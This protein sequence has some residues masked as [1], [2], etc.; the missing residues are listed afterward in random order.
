MVSCLSVV[1]ICGI[2][3]TTNALYNLYRVYAD[4]CYS[5]IDKSSS[6]ELTETINSMY[7][8][9]RGSNECYVFLDDIVGSERMLRDGTMRYEVAP[10][11]FRASRWFTRGWT[12]PEL[13]APSS[14]Y[15]YD[16]DGN[17]IASR[18]EHHNMISGA[19]GIHSDYLLGKKY[20]W[21]AS[22]AQR[23]SWAATRRTTRLE[24]RAYSLLGIFDVNLPLLY[25]EGTKAFLRLQLA[26]IQQSNDQSIFAW[27]MDRYAISQFGILAQSPAN[28]RSSESVVS[29]RSATSN[30]A[31]PI[32]VTNRGISYFYTTSANDLMPNLWLF[33]GTRDP[34]LRQIQLPCAIEQQSNENTNITLHIEPAEGSL[35]GSFTRVRVIQRRRPTISISRLLSTL[36]IRENKVH[37]AYTQHLETREGTVRVEEKGNRSKVDKLGESIVRP[38][39]L[40][41]RVVGS[42]ALCLLCGLAV[43][44]DWNWNAMLIFGGLIWARELAKGSPVFIWHEDVLVVCLGAALQTKYSRSSRPT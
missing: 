14:V 12:L 35:R 9:Y 23:M 34:G 10:Q 27:G 21:E 26:I 11:S 3:T 41:L 13:L 20:I 19:T 4:V 39:L 5:C 15:F 32:Q 17:L 36:L 18:S 30:F 22:I 42:F 24:D 40:T 8:W 38:A 1:N 31:E 2:M 6:A 44:I 43:M 29:A 33:S 28:F 7:L 37:I 16:Q 25:G